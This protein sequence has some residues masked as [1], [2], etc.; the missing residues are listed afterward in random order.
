MSVFSRFAR[1]ARGN[2]VMFGLAM[3]PV[4][5]A[6]GAAIDY[7]RVVEVR[8]EL[9]DALDG[10]VLEVASKAALPDAQALAMVKQWVDIHMAGAD[11]TWT[12]DSVSQDASGKITGTASAKVK[13]VIARA[14][15]AKEVPVGVKSEV[16]RSR[17]RI[18]VA[19]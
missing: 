18:D 11:A 6:V 8:S 15:G 4:V 5:G 19:L 3:V 16:M 1:S 2:V 13:T 12:V 7:S 17:P 10:G 9:A 14:L